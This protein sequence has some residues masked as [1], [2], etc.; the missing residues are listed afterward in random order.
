MRRSLCLFLLLIVS[1]TCHAHKL[2]PSLLQ[3]TEFESGRFEVYW[4]TPKL[5]R[6]GQKLEPVFP[7]HCAAQNQPQMSSE[8]TG[9]I[10]R[11]VL[12]CQQP[13]AGA[14]I[15]VKG[16]ESTGTATVVKVQWLGGDS[17]QSIV[18]ARSP[19]LSIAQQQ[20]IL[21]IISGYI[22]LGAEHI[23][24]GVDHLLF[25]LAL[26][27]LVTTTR[28]LVW[29]VTAFT[30]GHSI[31]LSL[32]SLGYLDYPV[33]LVE[34]TIAL[35]ILVLAIELARP[36]QGEHWIA[37]NSWLV[38]VSFG[39][40]H[41][42]GFAGALREVG[43]PAGDIPLA[44]FSFNVGIE[45]GQIAF[46]FV[47]LGLAGL[48]VRYAQPLK[49]AGRWLLVYTIGSMSAFWCIERGLSVITGA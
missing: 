42:M 38:A 29:T 17:I 18:N 22:V 2:A 12:H 39:L 5:T 33:S 19:E 47:C 43:L 46:V 4:K 7:D 24:M 8:G 41:G 32:V 14:V 16:M 31:T 3:L 11:W 44:L 27:M 34:F 30:V 25:V 23:W 35:S 20:T 40:L 15:A 6:A 48:F 26:V 10:A 9:V 1:G 37:K 21:E 28:K 36:Q 13:M 45:L 49:P